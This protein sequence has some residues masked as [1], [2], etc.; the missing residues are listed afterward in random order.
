MIAPQNEENDP[1]PYSKSDVY[2]VSADGVLALT[3]VNDVDGEELIGFHGFDWSVQVSILSE[4]A[5]TSQDVARKKFIDDV[6]ND[7]S[8]IAVLS[9]HGETAD[10]WITDEPKMDLKFLKE[11]ENLS[12]RYWSGAKVALPQ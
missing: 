7:R 11:G 5:G 8:I 2:H 12:F 4:V 10:V 9:V 1:L 6:L 3:I